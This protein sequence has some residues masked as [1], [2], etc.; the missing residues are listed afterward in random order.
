MLKIRNSD[1]HTADLIQATRYCSSNSQCTKCPFACDAK[2]CENLEKIV[3]ERME[4]LYC[5][6]ERVAPF[7]AKNNFEGYEAVDG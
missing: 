6:V 2:T 4:D 1:I 7:L 3:S 5:E